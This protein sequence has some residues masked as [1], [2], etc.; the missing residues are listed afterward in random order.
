MFAL[1]LALQVATERRESSQGDD[2]RALEAFEAAAVPAARDVGT[3]IVLGI[4]PDI[5]DFRQGRITAA[6]FRNDMVARASQF[7]RG[8]AAFRGAP[9]PRRL[10]VATAEF[11][12]S[13]VLY[14]L[15][16][17]ALYEAG[18]VE[19]PAREELVSLGA[20]LGN[21]GDALYDQAGARV[22]R[23]RLDLGLG[24]SPEWPEQA[25]AAPVSERST[26]ARIDLAQ[27]CV[28]GGSAQRLDV[29]QAP[30]GALVV[31]ATHYA[32]GSSAL[33][34]G[35]AGGLGHGRADLDARFGIEWRVPADVPPGSTAV[36]AAVAGVVVSASFTAGA[37]CP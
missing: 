21:R 25:A 27:T 3:G 17:V 4:R 16:V 11:D 24:P 1:L 35:H 34:R 7:E 32:D 23:A 33:S 6:V 30:A 10:E 9:R 2:R 20:D 28:V 31:Y 8:A 29:H 26:A 19:G 14:R 22:Q 12:R 13:F 18:G 36:V 15:A 37:T 5:T